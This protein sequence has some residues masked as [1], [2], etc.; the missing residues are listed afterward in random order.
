MDGLLDLEGIT[1]VL[2]FFLQSGPPVNK[3]LQLFGGNL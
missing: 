2:S 3:A 1:A